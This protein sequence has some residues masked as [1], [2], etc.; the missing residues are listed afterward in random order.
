MRDFATYFLPRED[1]LCLLRSCLYLKVALQLSQL[2][3][4]LTLM[5]CSD[6]FISTTTG[7]E[8]G[9]ITK[10]TG[11]SL[12]LMVSSDVYITT[13]TGCIDFITEVTAEFFSP[14]DSSD[15]HITTNT[16]FEGSGTFTAAMYFLHFYLC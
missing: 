16:G 2:N 10:I 3:E 14:M 1:L 7:C 13:T 9:F 15:V 5:V 6:V 4:S 12:T 11:E 8:G